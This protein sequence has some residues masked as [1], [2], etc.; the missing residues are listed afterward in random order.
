MRFAWRF[1]LSIC[2]LSGAAFAQLAAPPSQETVPQKAP[3][4]DA[5]TKS[6]ALRV[7]QNVLPPNE[8]FANVLQTYHDTLRRAAAEVGKPTDPK[9]AAAARIGAEGTP[10]SQDA[11]SQVVTQQ[12]YKAEVVKTSRELLKADILSKVPSDDEPLKHYIE[13]R[14]P[15]IPATQTG[16][17]SEVELNSMNGETEVFVME[18]R[19]ME[20][21]TLDL[22]VKSTP[23]NANFT[24][25]GQYQPQED[26]LSIRTDDTIQHLWRGP[27]K[28]TVGMAGYKPVTST[29]NTV[30]QNGDIVECVLVPTDGEGVGECNLK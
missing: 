17:I 11:K 4:Q 23:P 14:F 20:G 12:K 24:Y 13:A 7:G 5:P 18:L 16:Y 30:S 3:A 25:V 27:Y 21:F 29:F 1:C 10:A 6:A 22:R 15:R 26:E 19:S 2:L 9:A 8:A 28:C